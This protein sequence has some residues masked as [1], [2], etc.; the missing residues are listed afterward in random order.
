M[1]HDRWLESG[2]V[3]EVGCES[4][5][6][7]PELNILTKVERVPRR[8]AA[9]TLCPPGQFREHGPILRAKRFKCLRRALWVGP[10][11]NRLLNQFEQPQSAS[12]IRGCAL[13]FPLEVGKPLRE[14]HQPS[15][16]VGKF[17]EIA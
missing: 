9:A 6:P 12:G 7:K 1:L 4:G 13:L 8:S 14:I 16:L 17:E 5:F 3:E 10:L 15:G 2:L 11:G